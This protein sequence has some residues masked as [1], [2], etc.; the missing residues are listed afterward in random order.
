MPGHLHLD[1]IAKAAVDGVRMAGGVPFDLAGYPAQGF[2]G[3]ARP[4]SGTIP[5]GAVWE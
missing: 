3:T 2:Y 5:T 4:E 1:A